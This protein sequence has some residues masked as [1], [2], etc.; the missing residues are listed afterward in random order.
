[1]VSGDP[2]TIDDAVTSGVVSGTV[3]VSAVVCCTVVAFV[4][5]IASVV[6]G[7]VDAV[8]IEV[9]AGSV[10]V[11]FSGIMVVV[12]ALDV[13]PSGVVT[14]VVSLATVVLAEFSDG[15]VSDVPGKIA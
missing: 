10:N 6:P 4:S 14:T 12:Y 8:L 3:D 2:A 11:D 5:K 9:E 1:M 15:V 7:V 13:V